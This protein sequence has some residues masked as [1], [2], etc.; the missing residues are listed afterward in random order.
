M[1]LEVKDVS[2]R[3]GHV[4]ALRSVSFALDAGQVLALAG[5]NGSGKSTLIR[6][7]S[8]YH[9][10]SSGQLW[11]DGAPVQLETPR[12]AQ[13]L[14]ISTVYQ[15]LAVVALMSI[16]RNLF[17]GREE[18]VLRGRWPVRW[19]D[20]RRARRE[21]VDAMGQLGI[22]VRDADELVGELSGGERQSIA[23][24]RGIRFSARLLILDEPTAALSL[25][26]T[27]RVLD[28]IRAARDRGLAVV[29]VAHN[30]QQLASVADQ[31]VVLR[32]GELV[33]AFA[34]GRDGA[35]AVRELLID[36]TAPAAATPSS[37]A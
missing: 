28:S 20:R 24:A 10:P 3:F 11:W 25:R 2:K 34:G 14:G 27:E 22:R 15:D 33:G 36:A 4:E 1:L 35:E 23:I 31:Y 19:M 5:D 7:L 6:I 29:L 30:V 18:A 32:R 16:Y 37:R 12:D 8:G 26:Q 9:R 21:T 17:L 13:A